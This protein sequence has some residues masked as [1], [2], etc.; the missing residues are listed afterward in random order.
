MIT[1]TVVVENTARGAGVL[2]EHGLAWWIEAGPRC[3]LFDTGQGLVLRH[4]CSRLGIDLSCADS[5]V[6]SHG[7]YDHVGGLA[8][9]LDDAPKASI[10][11]HPRAVDAKFSASINGGAA[12]RIST[13]FMEREQ[14]RNPGRQVV[15]TT[16]P[17]EVVPGVWTT[18]EIPRS[19][20][21]EDT[22]GRF[23]LD[24]KQTQPDL[25]LD[26]QA[27]FF[28]TG[29]GVVVVLGCAHAGVVNTLVHI[30]NLTGNKTIHSVLG[31]MHLENASPQRMNQTI[32]CLRDFQVQR[33]SPMHCTGM[34]QTIA[35]CNAFP[36]RFQSCPVSTVLKFSS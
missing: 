36:D 15:T 28:S 14:F 16:E 30:A 4:N 10:F 22:G 20:D 35:L 19:N 18:G 1:I 5:I 21:F 13:D 7:H 31:G 17:R 25:L 8:E 11:M 27:V 33:I 6:L 24:E 12:R 9:A 29:E 32:S 3:V 23:F 34:K 2:G 26:D